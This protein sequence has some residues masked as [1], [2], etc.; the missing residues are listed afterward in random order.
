MQSDLQIPWFSQHQPITKSFRVNNLT[1]N[2]K[3]TSFQQ[4]HLLT[5]PPP[6]TPHPQGGRGAIHGRPQTPHPHPQGGG[7]DREGPDCTLLC[8]L[9]LLWDC[10]KSFRNLKPKDTKV[11]NCPK[12]LN[13]L[14]ACVYESFDEELY[15][16]WPMTV[17]GY[18][19]MILIRKCKGNCP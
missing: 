3:W 15:K 6:P 7:G 19:S 2:A 10:P 17:I 14:N 9:A 11:W 18:I 16:K 8:Q 1:S 5:S 12:N 4:I 13:N